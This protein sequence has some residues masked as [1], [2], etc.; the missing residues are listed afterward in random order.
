MSIRST[1]RNLSVRTSCFVV[2]ERGHLQVMNE[3]VVS[4]YEFVKDRMLAPV[5]WFPRV[6]TFFSPELMDSNINF[7]VH[8]RLPYEDANGA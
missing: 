1:L 5:G 2:K 8:G 4:L 3:C 7:V 6:E